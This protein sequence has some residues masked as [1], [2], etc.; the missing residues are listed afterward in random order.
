MVIDQVCT[1]VFLFLPRS[2]RVVRACGRVRTRAVKYGA[3]PRVRE[4]RRGC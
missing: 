3:D 1:Y 4:S 2:G